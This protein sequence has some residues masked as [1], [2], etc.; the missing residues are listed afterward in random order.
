MKK[1]RELLVILVIFAALGL[2]YPWL[3]IASKQL[4]IFGIPLLY[5]YLFGLWLLFILLIYFFI[6]RLS[7]DKEIK[8]QT[9]TKN[10]K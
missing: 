6:N 4:L 7:E 10:V 9:N 5:F 3:S 1:T 8:T 2:N